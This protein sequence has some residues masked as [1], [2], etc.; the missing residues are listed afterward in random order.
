MVTARY[1][2]IPNQQDKQVILDGILQS[3]DI[4]KK[5]EIYKIHHG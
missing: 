2:T 4:L 1:Q 3:E 5:P